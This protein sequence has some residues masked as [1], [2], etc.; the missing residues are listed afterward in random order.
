MG[1]QRAAR[2]LKLMRRHIVIGTRHLRSAMAR[3]KPSLFLRWDESCNSSFKGMM[4]DHSGKIESWTVSF[5]ILHL[6]NG[7][8]SAVTKPGRRHKAIGKK[9][10][11]EGGLPPPASTRCLRKRELMVNR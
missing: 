6:K 8:T 11:A 3:L 9:S 2:Q 1:S 7:E 4:M 5:L 10:Q